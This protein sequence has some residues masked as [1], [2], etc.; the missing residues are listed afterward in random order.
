[1]KNNVVLFLVSFVLF[2]KL[3]HASFQEYEVK[4]DTVTWYDEARKR[5]I[6][7][8]FYTPV[9]DQKIKNHQVILLSHGYGENKGY[10]YLE[11]SYIAEA[12][13]SRGCFVASIQHELPTDS[14]LAMDGI[15]KITRRSNWDRGAANILFV[16]NELKEEKPELNYKQVVLIGHSNGGDMSALFTQLYPDLVAKLITLDNRRM[17][18]PRTKKPKIYSIRSSDLPADDAVLPTAEEQKKSGATIV[19]LSATK[20]NEMDNDADS[21]QRKEILGYIHSFLNE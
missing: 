12:L 18:L 7:V 17:A 11:Y 6:P 9:T 2:P 15:L 10:A 20:H 4:R 3:A 8:A 19:T 5:I 14:L 21:L 13:A 1:M 16:L